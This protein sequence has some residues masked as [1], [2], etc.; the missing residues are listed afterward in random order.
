MTYLTSSAFAKII[1]LLLN[2]FFCKDISYNL[3]F[4]I[5]NLSVLYHETQSPSSK[6]QVCLHGHKIAE[7]GKHA[8]MDMSMNTT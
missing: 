6:G 4:T 7:H 5:V 3:G 2:W 1:L 8:N